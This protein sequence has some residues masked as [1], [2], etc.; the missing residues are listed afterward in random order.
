MHE[1]HP[2]FVIIQPAGEHLPRTLF[3]L[4]AVAR[5]LFTQ[6]LGRDAGQFQLAGMA[7]QPAFDIAMICL[8]MELQAERK[9]L[10]V[11]GLMRANRRAGQQRAPSGIVNIS[12]CQ[13]STGVSASGASGESSCAASVV[14][15]A[16]PIS[17]T[18]S[19]ITSAPS[20]G[21]SP[22]R[23]DTP[24]GLAAAAPGAV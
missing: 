9:P 20:A 8:Q 10:I 24:R 2:W 5:R 12:P 23:R 19:E 16:K 3:Q 17:L 1:L 11:E 14:S 13:C 15:G 22:E 4:C 18:P 21:R 7:N 6:A